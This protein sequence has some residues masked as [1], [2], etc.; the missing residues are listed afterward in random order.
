MTSLYIHI[1]F[2]Q[3]KCFYCSFAVSVGQEHRIETYLEC[4]AKEAKRYRGEAVKT[5]Y[6]GGGTPSFL[7]LE[8]LERLFAAI[9]ENFR[10]PADAEYTAEVNPEGL[11][12]SKVELLKKRGVN[13]ISM[14]V[15]SLNDKYLKILGRKHTR[16][17]ALEGFTLLKEAGF[18]NINL[19]LMFA[20]PGQTMAELKEDVEGIMALSSGHLSLYALDLETNSRFYAQH[21]QLP[22]DRIQAQYYLFITRCLESGGFRQYEISNFAKPGKE[23]RH[24]WN[25]WLCGDYIGLGLGAHSHRNGRR[26]W[27]VSRLT[28]Y[29]N[30]LKNNLS[31]VEGEERLKKYERFLEAMLFG[32]RTNQGVNMSALRQRFRCRPD[33]Q[34]QHL[35]QQ[36]MR[37][38]FFVKRDSC[39]RT[40]LKGR[41]VLDELC[42]KLI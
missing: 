38:G 40:T 20:F 32:L 29:M 11:E 42:S 5:I 34:R 19:D 37:E 31:P 16:Q 7:S 13:R 17:T 4:L 36:F 18:D 23:S 24:N 1:P 15:Q 6:I 26:Y 30:K 41:L 21:I 27:N 12:K 33:P 10:F 14:G 3:R 9:N 2:C 22:D 35:I 39:L 28:E 25:Y 8:Q